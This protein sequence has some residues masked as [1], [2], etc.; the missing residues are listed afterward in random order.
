MGGDCQREKNILKVEAYPIVAILGDKR[1]GPQSLH[2]HLPCLASITLLGRRSMP[3]FFTPLLIGLPL[4]FCS[5]DLTLSDVVAPHEFL[6]NI[7]ALGAFFF[8]CAMD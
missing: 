8:C 4:V 5:D 1:E 2:L 7:F 3:S 6:A